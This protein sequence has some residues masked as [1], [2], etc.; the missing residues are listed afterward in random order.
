MGRSRRFGD[1]GGMSAHPPIAVQR[2]AAFLVRITIGQLLI[3]RAAVD[4]FRRRIDEVLPAEAAIRLV[5]LGRDG[6]CPAARV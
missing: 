6:R 5:D 2:L 4:I 3:R 1:V